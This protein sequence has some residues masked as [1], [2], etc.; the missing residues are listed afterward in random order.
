MN[1]LAVVLAF[2]AAS[3]SE[4]V[5]AMPS[6]PRDPGA[7]DFHAEFGRNPLLVLV[8]SYLLFFHHRDDE[9]WETFLERLGVPPSTEAWPE[10]IGELDYTLETISPHDHALWTQKALDR[11]I[12]WRLARRLARIALADF[13]WSDRVDRDALDALMTEYSPLLTTEWREEGRTWRLS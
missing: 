7:R 5:E 8:H 13:G 9:P 6:L 4:Q 2:F 11:K 3:P 10:S 1:Q 12:G